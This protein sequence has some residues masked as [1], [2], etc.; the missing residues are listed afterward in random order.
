MN[1][2]LP[3]QKPRKSRGETLKLLEALEQDMDDKVCLLGIR[4]YYHDDHGDNKRG[5]YDDAIFVLSPQS[6]LAVN[7]NVDPSA[8]R[9]GIASL[10][11][12]N[13]L[14][15]LGIHGLSKPPAQQYMA[16]VQAGPVTVARDGGRRRRGISGSISTAGDT[17]G[18][19]VWGA[20]RSTRRSGRVSTRWCALRCSGRDRKPST[21]C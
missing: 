2:F 19:A 13:W 18:R 15:K 3:S 16:L 14:Y 20:R 8:W 1:E 11:E 9:P 5:I 21:I 6:F 17:T 4:G 12:G 7:A 10:K